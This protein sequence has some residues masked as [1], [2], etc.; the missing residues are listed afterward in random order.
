MKQS[1]HSNA[2]PPT[3]FILVRDSVCNSS[4][5][6]LLDIFQ[7]DHPRAFEGS[8]CKQSM[9][10]TMCTE[11]DT[12]D[13]LFGP[14]VHVSSHPVLSH[15]ITIL[16]SSSTLP[17]AFRSVMREVTYHLGYEATAKLKTRLVM[18]SVPVGKNDL[19]HIDV[20][21][22]KLAE[23]VALI[24]IL[25]SGLGMTDSM[26]ELLPNAG[27]HHIGMYKNNISMPV[28]YYNRLPRQCQADVAYVLDPVIAS[29]GT[30][31]S[32]ISILKKVSL[33]SLFCTSSYIYIALFY[34]IYF[35]NHDHSG[36]FPRFT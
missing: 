15:K 16:R 28:Q 30:T 3:R 11:T 35:I 23:R 31:M 14:N 32:L 18:V 13:A 29:G 26:L 22:T 1:E 4:L 8:P 21:G 9:K 25:R 33:L 12:K 20:E 5:S 7:F 36:E 10:H 6:A 24:P 19:D 27:V 17:G 34:K 2:D